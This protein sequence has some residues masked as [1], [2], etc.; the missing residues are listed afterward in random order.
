MGMSIPGISRQLGD[1]EETVRAHHLGIIESDD[2][3]LVH[4]VL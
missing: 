4:E 3:F 1:L 2:A